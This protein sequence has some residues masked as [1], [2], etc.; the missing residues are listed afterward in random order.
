LVGDGPDGKRWQDQMRDQIMK[1][2]V[3]C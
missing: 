2:V 1:S 3:W